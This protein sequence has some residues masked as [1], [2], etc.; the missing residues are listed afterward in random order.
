MVFFEGGDV[1]TLVGKGV[2]VLQPLMFG[3]EEEE[4]NAVENIH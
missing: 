3:E 1:H 2:C 4:C